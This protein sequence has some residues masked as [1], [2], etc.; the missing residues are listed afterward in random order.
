MITEIEPA[1]IWRYI[2]QSAM[3]IELSRAVRCDDKR[4]DCV[5]SLDVVRF[6]D[7]VWIHKDFLL[8][9]LYQLC[10]HFLI[11]FWI[12]RRCFQRVQIWEASN[13]WME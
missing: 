4:L 10:I 11:Y 7:F 2:V 1:F 5:G 8:S 3:E 9:L 13:Y 12:K 6:L